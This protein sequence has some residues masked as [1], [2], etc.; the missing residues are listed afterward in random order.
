MAVVNLLRLLKVTFKDLLQN[1]LDLTLCLV[2]NL[3][4]F[5]V[6]SSSNVV[7]AA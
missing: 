3:N 2:Q 6:G 7:S 5:S 1:L 4:S